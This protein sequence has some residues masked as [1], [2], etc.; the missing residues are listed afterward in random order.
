MSEYRHTRACLDPL[1]LVLRA[2]GSYGQ[3]IELALTDDPDRAAPKLADPV[4]RL[5]AA[6]ARALAHELLALA[7]HADDPRPTRRRA[8]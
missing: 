8:R 4:L 1:G 2:D 5:D 6:R 7:E 3:E